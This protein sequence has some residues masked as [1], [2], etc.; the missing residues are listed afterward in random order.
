MD[1]K[2]TLSDGIKKL[3]L[4]GIGAVAATAEKSQEVLDDLISKGEITVEQGKAL[5][6]EL[7]HNMEESRKKAEAKV[8][9]D[10]EKKAE[11]EKKPEEDKKDFASYVASL[12]PEELAA[13][14][15]QIAKKEEK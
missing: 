1:T 10:K 15:E 7:K 4:A 5:N 11:E 3:M 2:N 6:Q 9:A 13:L 8:A 14:K 12:T